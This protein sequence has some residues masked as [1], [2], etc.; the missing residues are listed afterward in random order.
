MVELVLGDQIVPYCTLIY[1]AD[2]FF[3]K[4]LLIKRTNHYTGQYEDRQLSKHKAHNKDV[5]H[6]EEA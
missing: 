3:P 4:Q 6:R 2:V 5:N 1:S